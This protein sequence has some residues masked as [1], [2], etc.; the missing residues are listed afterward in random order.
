MTVKAIRK[1]RLPSTT[2]KPRGAKSG[3]T[4]KAREIL[5]RT[6]VARSVR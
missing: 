2:N 5:A 4:A 6:R 3:L 1:I